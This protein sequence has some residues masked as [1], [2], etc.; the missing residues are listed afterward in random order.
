MRRRPSDSHAIESTVTI[1]RP[2]EEV[3]RFYRDFRNLPRY[4]GDVMAVEPIDSV[5]S[6]WTIQGPLGVQ[7]HWIITVTEDRPNTLI[8]YRAAGSRSVWEIHFSEGREA[9]STDVREVL[10]SPLGHF[11]RAALALIGKLPE[12]EV[13]ANL[14]RLKQLMETGRV[15][16]TSYA[17]PGKFG[18][19]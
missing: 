14:L 19:A 2:V 11:G 16:D 10:R 1:H 15:T 6:R 4:L 3:Y 18:G 13:A 17:V 12:K 9:G 7:V 5:T 8:R